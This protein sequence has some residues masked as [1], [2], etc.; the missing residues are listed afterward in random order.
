M[1]RKGKLIFFFVLSCCVLVPFLS[2]AQ[3]IGII[4]PIKYNSFSELFTAIADAI[5]KLIAGLGTVMVIVAGIL[6]LLSAG[7]Q[8]LYELAKSALLFAVLGILVG[9]GANSITQFIK[10]IN[11][12]GAYPELKY[13]IEN[14]ITQLANILLAL[15]VVMTIISGIYF[16]F[17]FGNPEKMK[18]ARQSLTYAIIGIIV[19]LTASIIVA[20]IQS[21]FTG[22]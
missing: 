2:H 5:S 19:G 20:F 1:Q 13:V 8:K 17:S 3:N 15:G 22:P 16:L 7:N 10:T 4:N 14:L 18:L 12:P 11:P 6:F 9:L 21:L